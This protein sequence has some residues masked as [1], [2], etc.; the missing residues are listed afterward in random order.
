MI[1]GKVPA[2]IWL[3]L[4]LAHEEEQ[5]PHSHTGLYLLPVRSRVEAQ[6]KMVILKEKAVRDLTQYSAEMKE[7]ER[8]MA[9]QQDLKVFMSTKSNERNMQEGGLRPGR[10]QGNRAQICICTAAF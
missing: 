7:L 10:R 3:W 6:S 1:P 4:V 2:A 9:H 5:R 8:N